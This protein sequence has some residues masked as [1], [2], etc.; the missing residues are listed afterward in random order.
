MSTTFPNFYR[1]IQ[2][3]ALNSSRSFNFALQLNGSYPEVFLSFYTAG[4]SF[5]TVKVQTGG[6]S[7]AATSVE[8]PVLLGIGSLVLVGVFGILAGLSLFLLKRRR[9]GRN[10]AVV[11]VGDQGMTAE[12]IEALHPSRQYAGG[13]ESC[14]ICL[15]KL[16]PAVQVRTLACGHTYHTA[17]IDSWLQH[18]HVV[19][20]QICCLCKYDCRRLVEDTEAALVSSP[21]S[22]PDPLSEVHRRLSHYIVDDTLDRSVVLH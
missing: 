17:C 13:T 15:D 14:T 7:N 5:V 21:K 11:P 3:I 12:Q 6:D 16:K 4:N 22:M 8:V 1:F 19:P 18:S 9:R 20:R 10:F 2:M